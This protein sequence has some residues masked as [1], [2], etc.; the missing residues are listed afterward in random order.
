MTRFAGYYAGIGCAILVLG[1]LQVSILFPILISKFKSLNNLVY[2]YYVGFNCLTTYLSR[3]DAL[4]LSLKYV[5]SGNLRDP[6]ICAC[7]VL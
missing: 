5:S 6:W 1:Y 7:I 4:I 2:N 3:T